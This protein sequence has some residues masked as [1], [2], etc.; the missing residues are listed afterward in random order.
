MIDHSWVDGDA[1]MHE[2][3]RRLVFVFD[4]SIVVKCSTG[5]S[6][7]VVLALQ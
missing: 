2:L 5:I 7:V 1:I 6:N 4:E 3:T